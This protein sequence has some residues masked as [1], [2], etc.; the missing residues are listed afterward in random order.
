[1]KDINYQLKKRTNP[2]TLP[3]ELGFGKY[4]TDHIFE[5]DYNPEKGWHNMTIKPLEEISLHPATTAFHYGQEIFEGMKAYHRV[6]GGAQLFRPEKNFERMNRSAKRLCMP[7]FDIDL[8]IDVLKD[9]I[10]IEKDWIPKKEQESLYIR[11]FMIG[12]DPF[13]GVRPS[14]N[15]KFIILL[16]PVAAYYPEGFKP[17][18][19]LVQDEYVRAVKRG[20]GD[21]KTA[22]NYAAS[23]MAARKANAQ[24]FTQVLWLDAIETKYIEEV[25]TMN[26]FVRFKDEVATPRL[27]G[28]ILPGVTR[29]SVLEMLDKKGI[30]HAERDIAIDEIFD[31]YEKENVLEMFGTGTAAVIS[32]VA[33]LK[34]NDK[35]IIFNNGEVG[36]LSQSLFDE[37]VGIQHG[38]IE[39]TYNWTV[40]V[41]D[42]VNA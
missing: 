15:Y 38:K 31:E 22:G 36:E 25:G 39:D 28:S 10:A 1:M 24:G 18:K 26:I 2:V 20:V 6:D 41:D 14:E 29:M 4:F 12:T 35:E 8:M 3:T 16:S 19:I 30:K 27:T 21:C 42:W 7:E 34:H 13:L 5:M 32:P 40:T 11:P 9:L 17:V 33:K 37:I 23:L